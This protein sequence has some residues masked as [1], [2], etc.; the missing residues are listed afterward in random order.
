MFDKFNDGD[1]YTISPI[2]ELVIRNHVDILN[3]IK[4]ENCL[5]TY[6]ESG[7]KIV[8]S[9]D[10]NV[11]EFIKRY[12]NLEYKTFSFSEDYHYSNEFDF[13]I[14][15]NPTNSSSQL[16][17]E[18][19]TKALVTAYIIDQNGQIFS[20]LIPSQKLPAGT[21]NFP[22]NIYSYLS[23]TYLVKLNIDHLDNV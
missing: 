7:T 10:T 11:M 9:L 5:N 21:Y 3:D 13:A 17:F 20:E 15:P 4:K 8:R 23:G 2:E 16:S 14:F 22:I 6:S 12:L 18:L 1:F 19:K